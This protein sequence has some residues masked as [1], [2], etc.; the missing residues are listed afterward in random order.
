MIL[1]RLQKHQIKN[2]QIIQLSHLQCEL[3]GIWVA[4]FEATA[5]EG[6][7]TIIGTCNPSDNVDTKTIKLFL[8]QH[9][10]DV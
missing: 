4:K 7:E 6:V 3:N 1:E 10:G 8:V 9:H 5:A 2:G